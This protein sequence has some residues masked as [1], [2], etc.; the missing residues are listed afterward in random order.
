VNVKFI[1]ILG[2]KVVQIGTLE[3]LELQKM[4]IYA[5]VSALSLLLP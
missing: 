1:G 5:V 2:S 4:N 3:I